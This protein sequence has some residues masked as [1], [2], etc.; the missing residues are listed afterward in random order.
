M[1]DMGLLYDIGPRAIYLPLP[2]MISQAYL[3]KVRKVHGWHP[4][5]NPHQETRGGEMRVVLKR[6]F[7]AT[8]N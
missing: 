3:I 7:E 2:E 6:K 5:A 8:A 1:L 4:A